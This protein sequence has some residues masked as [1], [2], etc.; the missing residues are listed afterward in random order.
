V[1]K[2][3]VAQSDDRVSRPSASGKEGKAFISKF[4]LFAILKAISLAG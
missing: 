1:K 3:V 2:R 4:N